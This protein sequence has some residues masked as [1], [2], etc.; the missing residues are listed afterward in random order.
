MLHKLSDFTLLRVRILLAHMVSMLVI[1]LYFSIILFL[2]W[3]TGWGKLPPRVWHDFFTVWMEEG[4]VYS[5]FGYAVECAFPLLLGICIFL[6]FPLV[7]NLLADLVEKLAVRWE[8]ILMAQASSS[9]PAPT[10]AEKS[11]TTAS[12]V[13]LCISLLGEMKIWIEHNDERI[14]V[15]LENNQLQ[16]LAYIASMAPVREKAVS[17]SRI[18]SDV[19]SHTWPQVDTHTLSQSLEREVQLLHKEV[20]EV[21][22]SVGVPPVALLKCE[23]FGNGSTKWWLSNEW[24]LVDLAAMK[25]LFEQMEGARELGEAGVLVL[26]SAADQLIELY[27]SYRGDYLEKCLLQEEFSNA[28]WVR[29]PFTEYRDMY[30]Q[31][32]WD[33]AAIEY[34]ASVQLNLPEDQRARSAK[35]AALLYK[36]YALHMLKNQHLDL[37]PEKN[38]RQSERALRGFLR[39]CR[40]SAD[41]QAAESVYSAY[42]ELMVEQFPGWQPSQQTIDILRAMGLESGCDAPLLNQL[43]SAEK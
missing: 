2:L 38:K 22:Q 32:L 7:K 36:T 20:N 23:K 34:N 24:S 14:S 9:L 28:D 19:F 18:L 21:T 10:H 8:A 5:L 17:S 39:V 43:A 29:R 33:A 27:Q 37:H 42:M 25:S 26:K 41:V 40:W 30:L 12:D 35:R 4:S 15:S 31:A 6:T 3:L 11:S 16:L 1:L 13:K